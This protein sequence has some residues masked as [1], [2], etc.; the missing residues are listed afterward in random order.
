MSH[1][2]DPEQEKLREVA[3]R[4]AQSILSLK[5]RTQDE[6]T[7]MRDALQEETRILELLNKTGAALVSQL[8]LETV[9]QK[10][11]DAC[12]E[13]SAARFGAF[14]YN[15][16]SDQGDA[17][18]LYTLSGA[19]KE[20][21]DKFGQPRATPI[22]APTFQGEGPI[23]IGDVLKDPRY[24]KMGPHFGMPKGHLPVRSYLAIP[25]VSRAGEVI[26]GLFFGHDETDM[27]TE[28]HERLVTGVA[29]QAAI[30]IDNARL[31]E[32]SR[33]MADEKQVLLESERVARSAAERMSELKDE[34]LSTLSH[35]LRTPLSAILG[36]S[37][38]LKRRTPMD[39]DLKKGLDTIERNA[40]NQAQLIEDLLDMSRITS[41]KMRLDIQPLHVASII[42]AAME[43]IRPS[44]DAK[45]IRVETVLDHASGAISGDPARL[46]QVIWNLLSNAIKFTVKGGK[47][48][49]NLARVGSH[50]E[51]SVADTG[52]GIRPEFLDYVF[53]RFRQ[54][55]A[56]TTRKFGGLG[57]GLAIVKNL[58][59]LHGGTV[60]A[61][62]E[63]ED[64]GSQ[65][66][67]KL[68]VSLPY[69]QSR[70][71]QAHPRGASAAAFDSS[72]TSLSEL[73]ILVVDDEPD[74]RELVER[75]LSECGASVTAVSCAID[76]LAA[77]KAQE[78]DVLVADIGMP[79]ID[80]YDLVREVRKLDAARARKLPA[81]ALTAF[82]R[83]EDRTR[84]LKAGFQVHVAKPV[85][86]S[87]L[88]ATV[89]SLC[90]RAA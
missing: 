26:G 15:V 42:E 6:V 11:T 51:I 10:L 39:D 3:M 5:Q 64:K 19:P 57:M 75:V 82:A 36:W 43:S 13:M 60:K 90:D 65:F 33:R 17:F 78:F 32:A 58:V 55:D 48:N 77:L 14:F 37:Q 22:F 45:S 50:I 7:R 12:T 44:A 46:Q 88:V 76:A 74:A 21:F 29:A 18:L 16:T 2:G 47:V 61:L 62:S 70:L 86:P 8:D 23:R 35:E 85:E 28:R 52:R 66:I 81:I 24:G 25:V 1:L 31:Y 67:V 89:A 63:G 71:E 9:V 68:P 59:E 38:V 73:R 27:F 72:E 30:A 56:S 84:A 54:G 80:G 20:A 79:D 69:A 49:V 87:E 53:D 4:N 41:G 83:S 34:F 40:R